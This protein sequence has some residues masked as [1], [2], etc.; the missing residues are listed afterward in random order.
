M[1][2]WLHGC[3]E[4]EENKHKHLNN[5]RSKGGKET[6]EQGNVTVDEC[7]GG[8][9]LLL[10]FLDQMVDCH[11]GLCD[12]DGPWDLSFDDEDDIGKE[13]TNIQKVVDCSEEVALVNLSFSRRMML[14]SDPNVWLA[15]T[16]AT[17]HATPHQIGLILE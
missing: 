14:R 16:A 17:V 5:Y 3:W 12:E 13:P 8:V 11:I 4:K 10:T 2:H 1:G 9:E 6:I 15:N 7:A